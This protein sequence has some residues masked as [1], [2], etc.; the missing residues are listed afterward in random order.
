[1]ISIIMPLYNAERF[2]KET[3]QSIADQ[4]YQEYE[5]ICIDDAS[6]DSTFEILEKSQKEDPRI[7]IFQNEKRQGAAFSRNKGLRY[8]QGD[9]VSFLDGDDLF[10]EEMLELAYGCAVEKKLDIIIFEYLRVKTEWIQLKHKQ[11]LRIDRSEQFK[12]KYCKTP[13]SLASV[14]PEEYC[15]WAS[16]PWN[17]LFR[18]QFLLEQQL[19][20]QNLSCSND[21]FFVEMSLFLADRMMYLEDTRVMVYVRDHNVSTR[22]S[23][24]RD[25]MCSYHASRQIL[26]EC[27]RRHILERVYE[28]FYVK[29]IFRL[30]WAIRKTRKEEDKRTFY[31]FLSTKGI[32]ELRGEEEYYSLLNK[33]IQHIYEEF[34]NKSFDTRWFED[35]NQVTYVVPE[36]R[37][38]FETLFNHY[39]RV[40]IWGAGEFGRGLLAGLSEI[41]MSVS[42]IT[43]SNPNLEGKRIGQYT[44]QNKK[45]VDFA[46]IDLVLVSPRGI[47]SEIRQEL[48]R[49]S[50]TII[51]LCEF[52][53]IL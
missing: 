5:L 16:A 44:V 22:I 4:T 8:A 1:M 31:E 27:S 52:L 17:K 49:F 50:M 23:V 42:G 35:V 34:Q 47:C 36:H 26:A 51:D 10:N 6:E 30:L 25:P 29:S 3:L 15:S 11:K 39:P 43:D 28:H 2:L 46:Q 13:F 12:Q 14:K 40:L 7:R 37:Q 41:G 45:N 19:E 32:Q 38:K 48:S 20:F 24:D 21:V 9:Y 33:R 53:D 18:R